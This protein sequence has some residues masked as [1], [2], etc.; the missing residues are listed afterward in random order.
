MLFVMGQ[1]VDLHLIPQKQDILQ[2]EEDMAVE[3][4]LGKRSVKVFLSVIKYLPHLIM[5][6]DWAN[7][8]LCT[9]GIQPIALSYIGGTSYLVLLFM[10]L[11]SWVFNFCSY[12]RV[13]IYYILVNN[14][15][16]LYDYY[17]GIPISNKG[18]LDINIVLIGATILIMTLLYVKERKKW[19]E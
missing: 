19:K 5:L 3:E 12:H 13:P 11:V 1:Q 14:T 8:F 17:V 6:L 15:L 4:R 16:V 9:F 10:L 18:L 7:T 2:T